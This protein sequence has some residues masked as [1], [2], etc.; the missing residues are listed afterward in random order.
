MPA[1]SVP[2][3][4]ENAEVADDLWAGFYSKDLILSTDFVSVRRIQDW[5]RPIASR[6]AK[7]MDSSTMPKVPPRRSEDMDVNEA[8]GLLDGSEYGEEGSREL[9]AAMKAAGL[10]A[11]FGASDD[12]MEFRGAVD[13]EAGAYGGGIVRFTRDGL[14]RNEC[15][16]DRCPYHAR[17]KAKA[18]TVKALWSDGGFSWRYETSIPHAKFTVRE[19]GDTYCEGI[20][21]ALADVP[22]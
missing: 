17:E 19:D 16:N 11:V 21:F 9:F 7:P 2:V 18:A 13:D 4:V 1:F 6:L 20:V 10:V 5:T 15:E 12:L 8:A 22:A 3:R 14:L